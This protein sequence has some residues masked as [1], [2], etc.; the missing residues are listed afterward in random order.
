M[1]L[2]L[3]APITEL[4]G[5]GA[6]RAALLEKLGIGT[7]GELLLYCPRDY[8]DRRDLFTILGAPEGHPVCVAA[9]AAETPRMSRIRKGL[10]ITR[11]RVVDGQGAMAVT[12]FNQSY[13][14]DAIRPG[15]SYVFYG[16]V[17]GKGRNRQMTNPVFEPED[18]R[19]VTGRIVPIYPLTAGVSSN[20]LTG[21]MG[22]AMAAVK[23]MTDCLPDHLR[24]EYD[25]ADIETAI[26]EV[27][28]PSRPEELERARRRMI[29]EELFILTAGLE[30]LKHRRERGEGPRFFDGDLKKFL[31]LLPFE[32][33]GA[34]RRAME[35]IGA[36]MGSGMPMNRL[37]QGDVGSGKTAVAAYGAWLAARNGWQT[38]LMAPTEILAEQHFR[39]LS[40]LLEPDGIRVALL[41]A[42]VKGTAR[43]NTLAALAAGDIDL[44]IGTH[45]LLSEGVE[46]HRLGL[47]VAD[48]QHRFGVTQRAS[49]A[50]K[51]GEGAVRPHVLVMS[52]TP[53]PRT[54]SLIIYGDLD[55]S[56]MNEMPPGRIPVKTYLI[57][58]DK[59][60]RM[61]GFV[62]KLVSE[63]RQ[64]YII[65]PAVEESEP[66]ETGTAPLDLKAVTKYTREL[67][68]KIFPD[69]RIG[70]VHGKLKSK[71]KET[72]MSAFASGE[73][74]VLVAT[75]VVEV[76]VDVANAALI[77]VENAERF[78]LSQ[79]HQLRG[80]VGRGRWESHCVLVSSTRSEE[81]RARLKVMTSTSD[82]F[83]IAEEDL[84]L[85]GPGDFFGSRQH[86]LPS[87]HV[88]DLAGNMFLLTQ[89]QGAA[90]KLLEFDP[91]LS[92]P[93][94]ELLLARVRHLFNENPDIFN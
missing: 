85:R 67:Q 29:F 21:L 90:R 55:V 2:R 57:G 11:V 37:V 25:L 47:V 94:H 7:V 23:E 43:K 22:Q 40:A 14:R 86:G 45:A 27:H 41:T 65:C 6:A 56:V 76:G 52:A 92:R 10:E 33:T 78:G 31:K 34:Q 36:D 77:V 24:A 1:E 93:E 19:R 18:R 81:S 3:T 39:S 80:R 53:I 68:E 61:Y 62:R 38:A 82:G 4:T 48:E 49:L 58:E 60:S 59:R 75:T 66:D 16:R 87:F 73:L 79:L 30:L 9:M 35:E 89:A 74:D 42:S 51:G 54:L 70:L 84:K 8:E 28:F 5:V 64:I 17:E 63:G 72:V 32:P 15:E 69:L 46:Y 91:E 12:F 13:I 26:R 44:I 20:L 88:A 50:A 83:K 71:E